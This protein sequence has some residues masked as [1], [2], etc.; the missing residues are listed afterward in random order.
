[1][2]VSGLEFSFFFLFFWIAFNYKFSF[3][4]THIEFSGYLFFFLE[5]WWFVSFK[6][7]VH[8]SKL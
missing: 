8:S 7:L 3:F 6:K 2:K 4:D 1:M 5:C